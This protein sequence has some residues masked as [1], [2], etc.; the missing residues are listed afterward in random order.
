MGEL[1]SV[2][3]DSGRADPRTMMTRP[4]AEVAQWLCILLMD[5]TFMLKNRDS[6]VFELG[7]CINTQGSPCWT[8]LWITA[9]SR[10][11]HSTFFIFSLT[12]FLC[13]LTGP[14]CGQLRTASCPQKTCFGMRLSGMRMTWPTH[15]SCAFNRNASIPVVPQIDSTSV[16]VTQS[17]HLIPAT[18]R[19]QRRWKWSSQQIDHRY[20]VQFSQPYSSVVIIWPDIWQPLFPWICRAL[21]ATS[22]GVYQM[23]SLPW[24]WFIDLLNIR[25]RHHEL[26]LVIKCYS[27]NFLSDC[28]SRTYISSCFSSYFTGCILSTVFTD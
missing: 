14:H 6:L 10:C 27:R 24:H 4:G 12:V 20:S 15:R 13:L 3:S 16:L 2:Q 22:S 21:P 26:T 9:E 17:C 5:C 8:V 23:H 25:L 19:K 18:L 7:D 1:V 11:I 28:Y